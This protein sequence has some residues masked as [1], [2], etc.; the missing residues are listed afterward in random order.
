MAKQIKV[1]PGPLSEIEIFYIQ[2]HFEVFTI[3]EFCKKMNRPAGIVKKHVE[4]CEA[5]KEKEL[6]SQSKQAAK[7]QEP[8]TEEPSNQVKSKP[9]IDASEQF[10]R[11][12][13]SVVMTMNASMLGDTVKKKESREYP[14][15]MKIK[16]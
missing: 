10:A 7:K 14:H 6:K 9:A 16:E 5:K 2:N 4:A 3:E 15:I 13:G 8:A 1:K 12:R 11:K